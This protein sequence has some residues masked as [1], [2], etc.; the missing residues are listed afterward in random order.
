MTL[1]TIGTRD[2]GRVR[3]VTASEIPELAGALGRAFADDPMHSWFFPDRPTRPSKLARLFAEVLLADAVAYGS[4]HTTDERD[5]AAIWFPPGKGQPSVIDQLRLLPLM[6]R[7]AGRR[8]PRILAGLSFMESRQPSEPHWHL[9]ILGV[10]PGRQG[11]GLGGALMQPILDRCDRD[12]HGAYLEAT[13]SRSRDLYLRHGFAV[14]EEVALPGGGPLLWRMWR[15][16][17]AV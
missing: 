1:T 7:L 3:R 2:T 14:L 13:S 9:P 12:G 15:G 17:A 5:G 4:A 6:V 8:L 16:P 11:R 10:E